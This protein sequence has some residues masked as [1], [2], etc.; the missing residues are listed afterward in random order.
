MHDETEGG[1]KMVVSCD[2]RAL[3]QSDIPNFV[4]HIHIFRTVS[5]GAWAYQMQ[6]VALDN[7]LRH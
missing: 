2:K 4:V 3:R 7:V 6:S 1:Y 5:L